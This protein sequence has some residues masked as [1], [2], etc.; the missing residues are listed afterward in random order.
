MI[1]IIDYGMGNLGSIEN[2]IKKIGVE[3][4]ITNDIEV[5]GR[6]EKIILPGVGAFDKAMENLQLL[7][8][9]NVLNNKALVDKVPLLGI[10]LGMQLLAKSSSEGKKK[11]LGWI[12]AQV[13]KFDIDASYKVPHMGWNITVQKKESDLFSNM[14]KN[15]R[16]YYVHSYYFACNNIEDRLTE[17]NYGGEF[18]SSVNKG[19]IYGVQFHPEKSHKFGMKL[20]ENFA[21][22]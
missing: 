7:N 18:T 13:L 14:Y 20:L 9:I 1:T 8:L 2:M 22:I 16:F 5:I 4:E 10:C 15:P 12:D 6:A 3:T 11:G 17:T 19:N 21:K